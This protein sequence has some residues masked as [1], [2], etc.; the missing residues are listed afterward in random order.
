MLIQLNQT[1]EDGGARVCVNK[2]RRAQL[3]KFQEQELQVSGGLK[4]QRPQLRVI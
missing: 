2:V 3:L 4:I 1:L